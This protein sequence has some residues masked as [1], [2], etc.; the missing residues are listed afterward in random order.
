MKSILC[1]VGLVCIGVSLAFAQTTTPTP[2]LYSQKTLDELLRIQQA[3]TKG[4]YAYDQARFMSATIGPRL[5]GSNEA[6]FAVKYV[7]DEMRKLGLDV[8]L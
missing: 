8:K 3:A 1:V 7:A 5:S 6:A 4:S 2:E